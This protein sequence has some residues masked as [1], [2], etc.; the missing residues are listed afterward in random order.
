MAMQ[1]LTWDEKNWL[2]E[3]K[4]AEIFDPEK[5]RQLRE[6]V[7]RHTQACVLNG[8]YELGFKR[9]NLKKP[10]DSTYF[11]EKLEINP[12]KI[13]GEHQIHIEVI[14]EDCLKTAFDHKEEDPLVLNM[15][16]AS[17]PGGGVENGSGAQEET[18]FRSSNYYKTLYPLKH[19][20]YPLDKNYGA[21]YSPVVTVFRGLESEGYPLLEEPFDLSFVAV[22]AVNRPA[23]DEFGAYTAQ[24]KKITL[25]KIR[26]IFNVAMEKHHNTL[27]LS[28]FGCGA[29][30]NPPDQMAML[31]KKVLDE[32]PYRSYFER[33]Y[34]SIKQDNNDKK[35]RNFE[36]FSQV[37]AGENKIF[38]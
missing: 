28:A 18:L 35:N 30:K 3:F 12:G 20:A 38:I 37:F 4:S 34:F 7:F 17:V 24:S 36:A 6:L 13:R 2:K 10:L 14:N 19:T 15:A 21:I 26:T 1:K 32:E 8:G 27:V 33:I 25:N 29:F 9:V 5:K 22:A 23:L 11:G 31:F 16:S